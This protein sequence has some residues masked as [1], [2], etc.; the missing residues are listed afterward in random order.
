MWFRNSGGV[1]NY[2]DTDHDAA[3][4]SLS[5]TQQSF[6]GSSTDTA[7][8]PGLSSSSFA[9]AADMT[10][11]AAGIKAPSVSG[12]LQVQPPPQQDGFDSASAPASVPAPRADGAVVAPADAPPPLVSPSSSSSRT[13]EGFAM[14][15]SCNSL[16]LDPAPEV[17][18]PPLYDDMGWLLEGA[19]DNLSPMDAMEFKGF[20]SP[21]SSLF[22][23]PAAAA[24]APYA[25]AQPRSIPPPLAPPS[26]PVN[27]NFPMTNSTTSTAIPTASPGPW[28]T[29]RSRV[30]SALCGLAPDVVESSF[31][32]PA[33]LA[34]FYELY[35]DHYDTHFPILHRP[36]L[37]PAEAPPL[38]MIAIV[39][40]GATLSHDVNHFRIATRIH[41]GLR[42]IVFGVSI[43]LFARLAGVIKKVKRKEN[44]N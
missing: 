3:G 2:T 11:D 29:V 31:F 35:F 13:A 1:V 8:P 18:P 43:F 6:A 4:D 19:A 32:A 12:L 41:D 40:L 24:P 10:E 7:P 16:F 26:V 21:H 5:P 33:N 25:A 23:A 15:G 14:A 38:L 37:H 36:T 27:P 28:S 34:E 30:L 20:P 17:Q 9:M 39:T 42:W 22:F 44:K